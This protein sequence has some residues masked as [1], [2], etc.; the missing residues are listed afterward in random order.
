VRLAPLRGAV[1]R[2]VRPR[3]GGAV[4]RVVVRVGHLTGTAMEF[5][6]ALHSHLPYVLNHGRWP[7][8]SDW[9]CEA[10]VDTYLPLLERLEEL[11]AEGTPTPLT[12]G[13]TPVLANQLASPAFAREMEAFF[14]QRLAACDE[15]PAAL[16]AAR[17]WVKHASIS[18]A[19]A[20]IASWFA[21]TGVKPIVSGVGVPSAAS[22]S[23]RSRRGRY[24][25]TAAS[26]SQ[27]LP[28]GQR[29]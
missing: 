15:A 12:I 23:S 25:S 19:K 10:A 4:G 9:L 26:H 28:W 17:R 3:S 6:L 2:A 1:F 14:T 7:H 21:S 18:R 27:S 24:V 8:G 29:P 11:A 16:T 13:F 5:V 22:S 20:G